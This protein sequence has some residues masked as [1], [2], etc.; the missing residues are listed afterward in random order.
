MRL[1]QFSLNEKDSAYFIYSLPVK[2]GI[3]GKTK[4]KVNEVLIIGVPEKQ[5]DS[6]C[7]KHNLMISNIYVYEN[8][9]RILH[10]KGNPLVWEEI[11]DDN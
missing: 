3:R 4:G 10:R 5:L 11:K 6:Y 7:Y 9:K 1:V 2:R 8:S